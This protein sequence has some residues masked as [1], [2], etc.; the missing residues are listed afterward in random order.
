MKVAVVPHGNFITDK[1]A[2][3]FHTIEVT[4]RDAETGE[5]KVVRELVRDPEPEVIEF[6]WTD[7]TMSCAC[8]RAP[9]FGVT[10]RVCCT[11]K[12]YELVSLTLDGVSIL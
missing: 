1:P 12:R 6:R 5:V 10:E 4:L 3:T 8:N 11:S 2:I 9:L 7:G